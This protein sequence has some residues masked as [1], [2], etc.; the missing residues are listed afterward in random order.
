MDKAKGEV[1]KQ[2]YNHNNIQASIFNGVP[3]WSYVYAPSVHLIKR[4][5]PNSCLI[6]TELGGYDRHS[7]L[8]TSIDTIMRA[9]EKLEEQV[10]VQNNAITHRTLRFL[11]L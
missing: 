10:T 5:F 2:T 7:S 6:P 4:E 9:N 3:F 1:E 11:H 8:I